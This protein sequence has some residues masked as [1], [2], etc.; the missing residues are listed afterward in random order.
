MKAITS[1]DSVL[2]CDFCAKHIQMTLSSQSPGGW[3]KFTGKIQIPSSGLIKNFVNHEFDICPDC[4]KS[5]DSAV[6]EKIKKAA[7]GG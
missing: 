7:F 4:Q 1:Q 2:S 6:I 5:T 3:K